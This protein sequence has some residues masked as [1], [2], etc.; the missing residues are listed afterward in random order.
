MRNQVGTSSDRKGCDT[1]QTVKS[2]EKQGGQY[3]RD[4]HC[5]Y[6]G[7]QSHSLQTDLEKTGRGIPA[8]LDMHLEHDA[9]V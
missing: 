5:M 7:G 8:H 6:M 4:K 9:A 1:G 3:K 2:S